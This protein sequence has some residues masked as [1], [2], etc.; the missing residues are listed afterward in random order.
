MLFL[1]TLGTALVSIWLFSQ[2]IKFESHYSLYYIA[3]SF[4]GMPYGL[5]TFSMCYRAFTRKGLLFSIK[6][7]ENGQ[8]ISRKVSVNLRDIKDI[9][10]IQEFK[11]YKPRTM[12]FSDLTI[13][14]NQ[15]KI[16]RIP[17]YNIVNY[18]DFNY[19]V[20]KNILPYTTPEARQNWK[21]RHDKTTTAS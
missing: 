10:I 18:R 7:G 19:N 16:I 17:T 21:K 2:G 6:P 14:T 13:R 15:N 8:I 9:Q 1:A 12:F 11:I 5:F 4:I 3:V 20:E